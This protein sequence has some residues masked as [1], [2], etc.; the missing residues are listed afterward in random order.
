MFAGIMRGFASS[1]WRCVRGNDW[2][3]ITLVKKRQIDRRRDWRRYVQ[4][5]HGLNDDAD[6]NIPRNLSCSPN[7]PRRRSAK[8]EKAARLRTG[9]TCPGTM[10]L[11]RESD[12]PTERRSEGPEH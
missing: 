8:M 6:E 7:S 4:G 9:T 5:A 3:F 11:S 12:N 10:Y 2:L 1:S